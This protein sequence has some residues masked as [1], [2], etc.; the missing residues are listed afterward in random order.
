MAVLFYFDVHVPQAIAEQ[1]RRRGVDVLT[2]Q[3]DNANESLDEELLE[4]CRTL[5]RVVFTQDIRFKA[6]AEN[7]Q[8]QNRGFAGLI[9]GHQQRGTLGQYVND[10]EI[11]AKASDLSDWESQVVHLPFK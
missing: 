5:G 7:W 2:A 4:R 9:F 6:R 8:R 11:I 10:L 3:E 1:L